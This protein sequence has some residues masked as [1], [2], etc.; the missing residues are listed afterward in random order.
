MLI[1]ERLWRDAK[2]VPLVVKVGLL[3]LALSGAA[4]VLLHAITP[5]AGGHDSHTSA[6][7]AAHFAGMVSMVVIL[8]GVVFDGAV[9]SSTRSRPGGRA[10]KGARDAVR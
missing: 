9:R 1:L 3:A 5:Q 10:S 6:E 7:L 2:A 8:V 4:D